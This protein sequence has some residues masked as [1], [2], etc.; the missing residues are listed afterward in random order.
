[1]SVYP[2]LLRKLLSCSVF[3][4]P[5]L[6]KAF[7]ILGG[8]L[9][10]AL[11][12]PNVAS[13]YNLSDAPLISLDQQ[14]VYLHSRPN[15]FLRIY[16]WCRVYHPDGVPNAID[17]AYVLLADGT[18]IDLYYDPNESESAND[19]IFRNHF[20]LVDISEVKSGVCAF[21]V[22]DN[23]GNYNRIIDRFY[24][25]KIEVMDV[26]SFRPVNGA[27]LT[28]LTPTFTW[29]AAG[30][31]VRYIVKLYD[32]A[33]STIYKGFTG[34]NTFD[35]PEGIAVPNTFFRYRVESFGE[36]MGFDRDAHARVPINTGDSLICYTPDTDPLPDMD[37]DDIGVCTWNSPQTTHLT[38]HARVRHPLGVPAGIQTVTVEMPGGTVALPYVEKIGR[39]EGIYEL[40]LPESEIRAGDYVFKA[41]DINGNPVE[42]TESFIPQ[43]IPFPEQASFT[44]PHQSE[45]TTTQPEF[46]WEEVEGA[47]Y[48]KVHIYD[49]NG[50]LIGE[51]STQNPSL[52]LPTDLLSNCGTFF[53]KVEAIR[54]GEGENVNNVGLSA[55]DFE[56]CSMFEVRSLYDFDGDGEISIIDIMKV[57]GRWNS[58]EGGEGYELIYD[59][60]GDGDI[61]V[62][63]IMGVA[64]KWGYY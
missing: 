36:P 22:V 48:Y 5:K 64:G 54:E 31:A 39:N 46:S 19:G 32:E 41:T 38:L 53:W 58:F 43:I 24:P 45:I 61:D 55:T 3:A 30:N 35:L 50:N 12:S 11:F 42:I 59:L 2:H 4:G 23:N 20:N 28:E 47:S 29:D 16:S 15:G 33:F 13:A 62:V 7:A 49:A 8:G 21:V 1:M 9:L 34:T 60:D 17:A 6:T 40:I 10:F 26:E 18:R 27:V 25:N 44:P 57:A 51:F 52:L 14:G 37:L 56:G 63:D